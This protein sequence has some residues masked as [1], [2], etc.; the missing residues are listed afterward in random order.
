MVEA[1]GQKQWYIVHTYSGFEERV[2]ENLTQRIEALGMREK[3]GEIKIPTETLVEMKGGKKRE[4][5]R[6]FFPGYILIEMDM[7]DDAWHLVKNTPKVTGFVG[8]GKKPTPLTPEEVDQIL[9]QVVTTK[10]KPKPK[11]VYEHGEHVRIIDGPFTN[12]TGVVEEVNLD[13]STLKVMVTI[14]G[15]STPVE[16]DF[17]QVARF[18]PS[19]EQGG[20]AAKSR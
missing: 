7:A 8:T 2:R 9:T 5:Q 11:H 6:K 20:A 18:D 13:R 4:V 14:F 17:L 1:T 3:F 10:E 12:F 16:L 15:R 19:E